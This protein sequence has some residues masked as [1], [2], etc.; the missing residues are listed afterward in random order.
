[1]RAPLSR[2]HFLLKPSC[3]PL[4][5]STLFSTPNSPFFDRFR[6]L[7]SCR[8]LAAM[9]G[10]AEDVVKGR[11]F[12]N[13]VAVITLDRPKALNA[14]NLVSC[15]VQTYIFISTCVSTLKKTGFDLSTSLIPTAG[16]DIKGVAAEIRKDKTTPLVPKV[17]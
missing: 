13:G 11:I 15:L 6:P 16:M 14:M 3:H 4:L 9:A 8:C 5:R 17:S 12:P 10:T 1:M 2:F 7:I